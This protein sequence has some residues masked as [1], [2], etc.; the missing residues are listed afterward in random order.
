MDK[1]LKGQCMSMHN[2]SGGLCYTVQGYHQL[3][4]L[5]SIANRYSRT[6]GRYLRINSMRL[7]G[8]IAAFLWKQ[9]I[10]FDVEVVTGAGDKSTIHFLRFTL[11][12]FGSRRDGQLQLLVRNSYNGECSLGVHVGFYRF[13]CA[14]GIVIG[15]GE[16]IFKVRHWNDVMGDNDAYMCNNLQDAV[17][18]ALMEVPAYERR[19]Q[20]LEQTQVSW[21]QQTDIML[22]LAG[23]PDKVVVESLRKRHPNNIDNLRVEDQDG[24]LWCV[25]NTV[26]E[27]YRKHVRSGKA[28]IEAN[29]S[30]MEQFVY[31]AQQLGGVA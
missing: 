21:K 7:I 28:E 25:L 19:M 14:N 6:S 12:D 20:M 27:T 15:T 4:E 16:E 31:V 29:V 5:D 22:G 17:S 3:A 13:V 23:V 9:D 30:L 11:A 1:G 18:D 10:N 8:C 26:N 2:R 24:N